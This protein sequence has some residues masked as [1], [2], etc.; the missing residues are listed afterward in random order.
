MKA[1]SIRQ[2]QMGIKIFNIKIKTNTKYFFKIYMVSV[3]NFI[4]TAESI[5]ESHL[6]N[7]NFTIEIND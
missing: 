2:S 4:Q 3:N 6:P 7:N 1:Q 5:A